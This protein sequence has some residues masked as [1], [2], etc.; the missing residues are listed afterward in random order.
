VSSQLISR[1]RR[2]RAGAV[3]AAGVCGVYAALAAARV[4]IV[5]K[6]A[7]IPT[8]ASGVGGFVNAA[9]ALV[10]PMLVMVAAIAPLVLI[11]G[12]AIMLLGG[13]HGAKLIVTALAMLLVLGS[14][15]ALI[16]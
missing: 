12:G 1:A 4:Q 11:A 5:V 16:N 15:T 13:R 10:T 9:N 3:A 8:N 14:V 2:L 6:A 7:G